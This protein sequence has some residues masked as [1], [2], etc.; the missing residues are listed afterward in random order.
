MELETFS[1]CSERNPDSVREFFNGWS[2]Y[3]RIVDNDYLCH[4]S[5]RE[6]LTS[7]LDGFARPFSFLDLGCGD[8]EFTSGLLIGRPL[9]SYTGID[10]SPVALDLAAKNTDQLA[11]PCK[12]QA[13][14][15]LTCLSSLPGTYD[16]IYIG[17]S[18]HHLPRREKE[19]FF[20]ELRSKLAPR[21]VLLIFDP[22]L[23]PGESRESYMGRWVDHAKWTWS[24]LSAEDVAG[25]V[26]HVTTSDYPEEITTLNHMAVA[27]GFQPAQ[28]LFTDR[29]DFYALLAF[30][31]R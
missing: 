31:S 12:L 5:V 30:H 18:L 20:G 28:P 16:I 27:A 22:V 4:R 21:G 11:V 25:A 24:A 17:L 29:A 6:A 10:L 9:L 26:E 8:A 2:L 15:F 3:R 13:G 7:W 19:F 23:N 14:D 1:A